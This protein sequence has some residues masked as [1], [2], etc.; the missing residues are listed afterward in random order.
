MYYQSNQT[1]KQLQEEME[2]SRKRTEALNAALSAHLARP[3]SPTPAPALESASILAALEIPIHESVLNQ[4][5]PLLDKLYSSIT[6]HVNAKNQEL[7]ASLWPKLQMTLK[8]VNA[9]AKKVEQE[10]RGGQANN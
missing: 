2:R 7:N 9:I 4:V 1:Y 3:P 6:D 8:M 5:N 10:N